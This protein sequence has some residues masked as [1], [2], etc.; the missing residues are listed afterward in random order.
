MNESKSSDEMIAGQCFLPVRGLI[1]CSKIGLLVVGD[2]SAVNDDNWIGIIR[3]PIMI[4][5]KC[6]FFVNEL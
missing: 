5:S 6:D 3:M 2:C 4:R 1:I